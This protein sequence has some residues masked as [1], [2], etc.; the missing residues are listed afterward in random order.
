M[1][2]VTG[3]VVALVALVVVVDALFVAVYFLAALRTESDPVKIGFTVVWTLV[4]LGVVMRGLSRV[5]SA[6][7][8]S[9]RTKP[10]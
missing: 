10:E 2:R 1:K 6:R 8:S 9:I 7:L 4:T 3:E 5:R